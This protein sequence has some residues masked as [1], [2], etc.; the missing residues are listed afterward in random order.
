M[1]G[2]LNEKMPAGIFWCDKNSLN[3]I[4]GG[5]CMDIY[6]CI[7][8]KIIRTEHLRTLYVIVCKLYFNI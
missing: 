4:L 1:R 8:V 3:L 2:E 6:K 7:I 5:S